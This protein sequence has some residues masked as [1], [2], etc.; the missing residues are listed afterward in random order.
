MSCLCP[1]R[2]PGIPTVLKKRNAAA[3]YFAIDEAI[4]I[5]DKQGKSAPSAPLPVWLGAK[6]IYVEEMASFLTLTGAVEIKLEGEAS[7]LTS[8]GLMDVS[9]KE[10]ASFLTSA[11]VKDI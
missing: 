1:W 6:E 7:F 3:Y 9:V 11:G 4:Y 5:K 8:I 10:M 2:Q